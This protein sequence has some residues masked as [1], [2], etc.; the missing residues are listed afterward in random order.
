MSNN[1]LPLSELSIDQV[2]NGEKATY[3]VPIYQ[4]NYAWGKNEIS[5]LVQDIYDA[6]VASP[7]KEYHIGTL[8]SFYKGDQAYEVIDGQQ[9]LTTLSLLLREQGIHMNNKLTY[10]A[11]E[12][13]EETLK[14]I[15]NYES[16]DQRDEGIISGFEFV[17][18]SVQELGL[19]SEKKEDFKNYLRHNVHLIHY[20]VP[21]DIDLNHYFEIM[22]SR[23]EQLEKHEIIKARLLEKL[24]QTDNQTDRRRFNLLWENC[25]EMG[26]YI[27][28][29]Y[30]EC[31][32]NAVFGTEPSGFNISSF[33]ELPSPDSDNELRSIRYLIANPDEGEQTTDEQKTDRFQ[34]IIDFPNFL[35]TVLKL[36]RIR[37]ENQSNFDPSEFTLDDKEL[38]IEFDKVEIDEDFVKEFGVNL[39]KAKYFLDNYFVHHID[40]EYETVTNNP[41]RLQ[42][43]GESKTEDKESG[44]RKKSNE[45]NLHNLDGT[46]ESQYKLTQLLS[47]FEVSFSARQRKNYLF[48]CMLYLFNHDHTDIKGYADF[49]SK[50]AQKY[51]CDI[52][53]QSGNLNENNK[54][55]PRVF[56]KEILSGKEVDVT[57]SGTQQDF[58]DIYGKGSEATKGIPLFVFNYL[59]YKLW[60]KYYSEIRGEDKTKKDPVRVEFFTALGCSDFDLEVFNQFYFSRSRQSLEHFY[61]QANVSKAKEDSTEAV[62]ESREN[63]SEEERTPT[64]AEINC[65]G[66]Y[67]MIGS[68]VNSSGSN[69]SPSVKLDHYLDVASG[70][71]QQVSVASLKFRI[72]MQKCEDNKLSN[73]KKGKEWVFTDIKT[74]QEHMLRILDSH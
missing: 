39:L 11:R 58:E 15:P 19:E 7:E 60:E 31:N 66:N 42:Y 46:N 40:E 32:H 12:K 23:G 52:Y 69:N 21:K 9:R 30:K 55:K 4:R 68:G 18:D 38:I 64:E 43:W 41:W 65:F 35:L 20:R 50:L 6:Y 27:Q 13:S 62:T 3:E 10:R 56:D 73:R 45:Y 51:Y 14:K 48:Y 17:K 33:E 37:S 25:S 22:N 74:H 49:V 72:M 63:V 70:K 2:F 44:Q 26:V 67:A 16:I 54:P 71:I 59:D 61:P 53:L 28:Q 5:T 24:N 34:P 29:K 57:L 47:M 36:T 8:V 1:M